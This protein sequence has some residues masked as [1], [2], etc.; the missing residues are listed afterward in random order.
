MPLIDA[1]KRI[2]FDKKQDPVKHVWDEYLAREKDVYIGI[3]NNKTTKIEGVVSELAGKYRFTNVQMCAFLDGIHE[4]V[5]GLPPINEVEEDT[6]ISF[7]VEFDRLYRQMVEYKAEQLYK[8][9]EWNNIFTPDEQK[10]LYSQQKRSH[11]VV[12]NES[13]VGRNE[14]CPCGSGKKHKNCCLGKE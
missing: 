14:P 8:L 1:W 12:R 9:G 5:D 6:E 11:T 3:L 7:E 10:E 2:A 4:C 13:K